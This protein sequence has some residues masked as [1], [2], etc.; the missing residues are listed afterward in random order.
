MLLI[1]DDC[2]QE[3]RHHVLVTRCEIG[4][5][6]GV[7]LWSDEVH[8]KVGEAHFVIEELHHLCEVR[9]VP[10]IQNNIYTQPVY[11]KTLCAFFLQV[12]DRAHLFLEVTRYTCQAVFELRGVTMH[13][14][15][16][17]RETSIN[18]AVGKVMKA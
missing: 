2:F 18:D 10:S 6:F 16:D 3:T 15:G 1:Q 13:G 7:A 12:L 17:T 9:V 4:I 5:A 14:N 8:T 11:Q